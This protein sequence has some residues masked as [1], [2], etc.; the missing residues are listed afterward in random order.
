M[1]FRRLKVNA[2]ALAS[3]PSRTA[4]RYAASVRGWFF[5]GATREI[6]AKPRMGYTGDVVRGGAGGVAEDFYGRISDLRRE[7]VCLREAPLS[8]RGPY[9]GVHPSCPLCGGGAGCTEIY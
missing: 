6:E 1:V 2:D 8:L 3:G 9:G 4:G 7:P 5:D